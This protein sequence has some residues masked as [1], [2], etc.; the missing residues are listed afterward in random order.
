MKF[1]III[2]IMII[3]SNTNAK[4]NTVLDLK[5]GGIALY[6]NLYDHLTP[7][8]I[9][10]EKKGYENYYK[11]LKDPFDFST[12]GITNH[13]IINKKYEIVEINFKKVK[14]QLI[15]HNI[16]GAE[17][18]ENI[19]FCYEDMTNLVNYISIKFL[20]LKKY[21]PLNRKHPADTLEESTYTS[22]AFKSN[23]NLDSIYIECYDWSKRLTEINRWKDNLSFSIKSNEFD[24]W[25]SKIK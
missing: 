11:H 19:N 21:G 9:R 15:V 7:Q 17:F 6:D 8:Q 20:N 4:S 22:V 2:F 14:G 23:N 5:I 3:S 18:Y 16:V 10:E 12:I 24:L 25:K 1:I 13:P